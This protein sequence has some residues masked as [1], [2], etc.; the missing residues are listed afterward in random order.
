MYTWG[1]LLAGTPG[2]VLERRTVRG[3]ARSRSELA[4]GGERDELCSAREGD[5]RRPPRDKRLKH[6]AVVKPIGVLGVEEEFP[7][8]GS[9]GSRPAFCARAR[10]YDATG[11]LLA[12]LSRCGGMRFWPAGRVGYCRFERH[13]SSAERRLVRS[14]AGDIAAS[15]G[16]GSPRRASDGAAQGTVGVPEHRPRRARGVIPGDQQALLW[17]PHV[18][19]LPR[20]AQ[21][22]REEGASRWRDIADSAF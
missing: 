7:P 18:S 5:A 3:S 15:Q 21:P 12:H 4:S 9:L 11:S 10:T 16:F 14:A 19:R 6:R 13:R 1:H 2:R 22:P 20:G 17:E 8:H